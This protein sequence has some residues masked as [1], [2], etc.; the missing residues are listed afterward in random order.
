MTETTDP[1]VVDTSSGAVRG[2][3][4]RGVWTFKGVPYGADTSGAGRFRPPRPAPAHRRSA[5]LLR[6]RTVVPAEPDS[7]CGT[8]DARDREADGTRTRPSGS[9]AKTVSV[10]TCGAPTSTER[11]QAGRG[12]VARRRVQHGIGVVAAVRIRQPR[13]R[14]RRRGGRREPSARDSL[15][16]RPL[17]HRPHGSRLGQRRNA[18]CGRRARMG[19]RQHRRIRRRPRQRDGVRRVRWR[20]QDDG[21]DGDARRAGVCSTRPCR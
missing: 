15:L 10:S 7:R 9:R 20:F 19:A 14:P 18:R 4:Q 11:A 5:R 16:P 17:E 13:S 1:G 8:H 3:D 12:V 6:L 21:A 2:F